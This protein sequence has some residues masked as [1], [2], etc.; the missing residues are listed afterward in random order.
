MANIRTPLA[1]A[2]ATGRTYHDAKRFKDRREPASRPLG[3]PS[4]HLD[5]L[6]RQVWEAFRREVTW[7]TEADRT[8][9]EAASI[10][11][12]MLWAGG[13][14]QVK[15]IGKLTPLLSRMGATP[16]D[17]SRVHVPKDQEASPEDE[18]LN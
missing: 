17:R 13:C 12:A 14:D 16:A 3:K 4:P 15:I 5:D 11:R 8:T 1:K 2:K 7:L 6:Q 9:V 10:L 18:F